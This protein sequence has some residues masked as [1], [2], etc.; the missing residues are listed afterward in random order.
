MNIQ[1]IN[2]SIV[3]LWREDKGEDARVP[4][5]YPEVK[6]G[7]I[8]FVGM[9]PSFSKKYIES[10]I[11]KLEI[12][13]FKINNFDNVSDNLE[14]ENIKKLIEFDMYAR[15]NYPYFLKFK[16]LAEYVG[17]QDRWEHIDLFCSRETSQ[18]DV[19]NRLGLNNDK[20][21]YTEFA[22][23]QLGIFKSVISIVNPSVIIV[24]NAKASSIYKDIFEKKL[25]FD[26]DK[27]YYHSKLDNSYNLGVPTFLTSM[28]TGQRALDNYS[29]ERLQ[30]HVKRALLASNHA[31]YCVEDVGKKGL[32]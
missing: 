1:D 11:G 19:V 24:A 28:F 2:A 4:Y 17:M 10:Y 9:N 22:K 18:R 29:F 13:D 26:D 20:V 3:N 14:D 12:S 23:E 21:N 32:Y 8:L 7:G 5:F 16:S 27:G 15:D 30:W 6:T 25:E 31:R